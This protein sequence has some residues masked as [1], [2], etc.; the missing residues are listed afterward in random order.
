MLM[1]RSRL[2]IA[3]ALLLSA[4]GAASPAND[5]TATARD[6]AGVTIVENPAPSEGPDL[7]WSLGAAP[8]LDI[9]AV[10]GPEEYQ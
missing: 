6:S 2:Q 1:R 5:P 8:S 9:G 7:G 10:D 4:C 3:T